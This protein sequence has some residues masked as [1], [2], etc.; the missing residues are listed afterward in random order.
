MLK[1]PPII[2][3]LVWTTCLISLISAAISPLFHTLFEITGPQEW[4][5]L[6]WWGISHYFLWQPISFLFVQTTSFGTISF[7]F[8]LTLVFN[9][10]LLWIMGTDLTHLVGSRPF[11][12]FYLI[13]G[14]L[15]GLFALLFM[16]L[17]GQYP[18]LGES[19]PAI[20]AL[21]T[22]WTLSQPERELLFFFLIPLKAKWLTLGIIASF[23]LISISELNGVHFILYLSA[24]LIGYLYALLAWGFHSPF[25]SFHSYELKGTHF[26]QKW[27]NRFSPSKTKSSRTSSHKVLNMHPEK[28]ENDEAFIDAM[29]EK[30]SKKGESSLTWLEKEKMKKISQ[31][32][33][34][35]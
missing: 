24:P 28:W 29:L 4:L 35:K 17:F 12:R 30:I 26:F 22:A 20:L 2:A 7:S 21:L 5:S 18:F 14:L 33:Q 25:P 23:L 31:K 32:K 8:L 10:S 11:L 34:K 3:K 27:K 6:S 16:P 1:T 13:S 15:S 9:M 19:T